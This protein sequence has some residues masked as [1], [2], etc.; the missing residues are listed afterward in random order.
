MGKTEQQQT[1]R[2]EVDD[3]PPFI[4]GKE[5]AGCFQTMSSMQVCERLVGVK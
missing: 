1:I 5:L 2:I 3:P 4:S